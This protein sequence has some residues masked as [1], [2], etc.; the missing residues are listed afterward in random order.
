MRRANQLA[1]HD[2]GTRA[3]PGIVLFY[4]DPPYVAS[5]RATGGGEYIH[6][7]AGD[8]SDAFH[9]RLIDA[10]LSAPPHFKFVVSGYA[11]APYDD[12]LTADRGWRRFEIAKAVNAPNRRNVAAPD[13]PTAKRFATETIWRNFSTARNAPA[14][15]PLWQIV[16]NRR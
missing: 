15:D 3:A 7:P 2:A 16:R 5:T 6:D 8:D 14:A 12:A 9:R 10:L 11:S 13:A 4:A 1:E